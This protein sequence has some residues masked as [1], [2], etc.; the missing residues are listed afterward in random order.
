MVQGADKMMRFVVG[1]LMMFGGVY[2]F[3][4]S[5]QVNFGFNYP[6]YRFGRSSLTTGYILIPFMLGVGMIFFNSKSSL[7]WLVAMGSLVALVLGVI[8]STR[9]SLQNMNAFQLLVILVLMVGGLGMWLSST[10]N[11]G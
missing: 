2:L 6:V 8:I 3:L 11:S 4:Q 9:F 1:V 10:R 7:G 5:V